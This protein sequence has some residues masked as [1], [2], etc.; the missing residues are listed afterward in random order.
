M[1][2]M[3]TNFMQ[4]GGSGRARW[5]SSQNKPMLLLCCC[6]NELKQRIQTLM[7]HLGFMRVGW[8][9]H[10]TVGTIDYR[11]SLQSYNS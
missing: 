11:L 4:M 6:C 5:S 8:D 10:Y 2:S 9:Q 1:A 7:A 3:L